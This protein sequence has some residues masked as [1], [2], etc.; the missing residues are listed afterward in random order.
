MTEESERDG[1]QK[2]ASS[3]AAPSK[4]VMLVEG[5]FRSTKAKKEAEIGGRKDFRDEQR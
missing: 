2:L 4:R 3:A 1:R 5:P